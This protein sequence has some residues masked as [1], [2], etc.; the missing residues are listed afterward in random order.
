MNLTFEKPGRRSGR[1]GVIMIL[2][3]SA[4]DLQDLKNDRKP[5]SVAYV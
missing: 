1:E 4:I 5:P 2:F 3:N